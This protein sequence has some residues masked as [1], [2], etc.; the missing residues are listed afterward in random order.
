MPNIKLIIPTIH[1]AKSNPAL[2]KNR[3]TIP[4]KIIASNPINKNE[5]NLWSGNFVIIPKNA[6]TPNTAA[7]IPNIIMSDVNSKVRKIVENVTPVTSEYNR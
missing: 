3:F 2:P 5:L 4:A 6:N 1:I 7:V